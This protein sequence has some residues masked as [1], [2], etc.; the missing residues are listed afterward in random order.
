MINTKA[1]TEKHMKTA[2]FKTDIKCGGCISKVT[3]FLNE[4]VGADNWK[5][6]TNNPQKVLTVASEN[7]DE[8]MVA[9]AVKDAGFKAE[10]I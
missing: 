1:K 9:K 10:K 2:Q 7:L 5:V 4:A 8:T 6:D 3:P